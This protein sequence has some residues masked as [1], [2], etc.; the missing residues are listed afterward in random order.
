MTATSYRQMV[1]AVA[2]VLWASSLMLPAVT[3]CPD[4]VWP[5]WH[6]VLLGPLGLIIGQFGWYANPLLLWMS[7]RLLFRYRAGVAGGLVCLALA[8]T[9]FL[10]TGIHGFDKPAII[11]ERNIGFYA[12]I[13]TAVLLAVAA[14]VE[15]L[16]GPSRGQMPLDSRPSTTTD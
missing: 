8:L 13:A 6:V 10:W 12:W 4:I 1:G 5:G 7:L 3:M 11:C 9:S 2:L 16:F 14:F 15:K